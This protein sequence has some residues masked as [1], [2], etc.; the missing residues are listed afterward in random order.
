M[1][2]EWCM[3]C[4]FPLRKNAMEK[5]ITYDNLPQA[6]AFISTEVQ[7]IKR[8][9]SQLGL[10][11]T[12]ESDKLLTIK[13]ASDLLS[14]AVPSIY[15]LVHRSMIPCMKRN[16]RLYFSETELREW[17]KASRRLTLEEIQT[18]ARESLSQER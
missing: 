6:V 11:S 14:L 1:G 17:L 4:A 5:T 7:E 8:L 3:L 16:K 9:V 2:I 12:P 15:G 13:Q 10:S 18:G